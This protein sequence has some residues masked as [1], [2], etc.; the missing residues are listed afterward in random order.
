MP[1]LLLVLVGIASFSVQHGSW[2]NLVIPVGLLGVVAGAF[3]I[4]VAKARLADSVAHFGGLLI[5]VGVVF[6]LLLFEAETLGE[7]WRER[8]RPLGAFLVDWYLGRRSSADHEALLISMLIGLVVWLVG[9]LSAWVL[10]RRGWIMAAIL[11]PGF[12]LTVNLGYAPN[13]SP[14]LLGVMLAVGIPLVATYRH[15]QR[16]QL[17]SRHRMP[18]P[19]GLGTRVLLT[20][21]LMAVLITGLS[22]QAPSTL[23]QSRFQPV[24]R[25]LTRHVTATQ[26]RASTWLEQAGGTGERVENAGSYTAFDDAFSISGPV[27]LSDRPEVLVIADVARAPYLTAH[28]YDVYTGRGWESGV[29]ATFRR[30]GPDGQRYSPELL[31]REGQSVV[32]TPNVTI[33]RAGQTISVTPLGEESGVVLSIGTYESASIPAVVRMSWRQ[34]RDEAFTID[35]GSL[36]ALPPDL[37]LIGSLLIQAELSGETGDHGPQALD[38]GQQADIAAEVENLR[39]RMVTVRWDADVDGDV[40]TLYVSGQLPVYDDVQAIFPR[41]SGGTEASGSYQVTG[42]TST[43]ED[44]SLAAA[45]ADYPAWVT[46][47]Y[48]QLGDTVTPRTIDLAIDIAGDAASPWEQ[49]VLV[50]QWLRSNVV[51]DDQVTAPPEDADVVDYTLFEMRRGYCEHYATSMTV[52]MRALGVPARTVVGYHPGE[53]DQERGGFLYRQLNAHA[54][55]EVFFPG[56]GWIP[57]EPTANRPLAEREMQEPVSP[58]MPVGAE[59]LEEGT[60]KEEQAEGG[61]TPAAEGAPAGDSAPPTMTTVD[62]G[63][64]RPGWLLPAGAGTVALVMLV[65]AILLGWNWRFRGLSPSSALFSRLV[66]VGRL[67]GVKSSAAMTPREYAAGFSHSLPHAGPAAYRIVQVYE[68]DQFGPEGVDNGRLAA[69]RDAWRQVRSQIPRLLFRRRRTG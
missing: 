10:F 56:Y 41:N 58:E 44:A 52:L 18:S 31:F 22:W 64:G 50:E 49:A 62:E 68:L 63:G 7:G 35:A 32:L 30:I 23:S 26:N 11:L 48:L 4:M 13:T 15:Y 29:D 8:V 47:R 60:P 27:N 55:T 2:E 9:Y 66:R 36:T 57:F 40:Q 21:T 46:D 33:D 61:A 34:L 42:M 16:R 65:G 14:W 12:L 3:G 51:Y 6:S 19:L 69:A 24:L 67:G 59:D 45:G 17:W 5:G 25:D 53:Y 20:S 43:A 37:Q 38:P 1:V 54:W 39:D 28:S